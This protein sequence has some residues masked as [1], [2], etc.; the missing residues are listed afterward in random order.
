VYRCDS[1][2]GEFAIDPLLAMVPHLALLAVLSALMLGAGLLPAAAA[3]AALW[4]VIGAV[5]VHR[6]GRRWQH[7]EL[8]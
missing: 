5:T 1:C 8:R 3:A 2:R 7:P 6:I 4:L